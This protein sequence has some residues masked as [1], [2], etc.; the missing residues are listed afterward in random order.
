[1]FS[2]VLVSW[3]R[4]CRGGAGHPHTYEYVWDVT[5][6]GPDGPIVVSFGVYGAG[7]NLNKAPH[8]LRRGTVR[9]QP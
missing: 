4:A 3:T 1:M 8:L 9:R 6:N 5:P 7:G 2:T